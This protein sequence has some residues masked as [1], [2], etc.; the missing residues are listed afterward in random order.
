MRLWR[1]SP[2]SNG[3]T[4]TSFSGLDFDDRYASTAEG[5]RVWLYEPNSGAVQAWR[6]F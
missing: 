3:Y 2:C 1:V 4:A 6:L 5:N